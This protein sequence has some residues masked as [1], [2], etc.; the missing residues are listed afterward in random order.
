MILHANDFGCV[1]DDR[2]LEWVSIA[3]GSTVLT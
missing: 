1:P 2:F 3:A